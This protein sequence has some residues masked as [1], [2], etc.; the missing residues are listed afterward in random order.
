MI[1][2]VDRLGRDEHARHSSRPL[3]PDK[4]GDQVGFNGQKA[5]KHEYAHRALAKS[6]LDA[7]QTATTCRKNLKRCVT[8]MYERRCTSD[9]RAKKQCVQTSCARR[10]HMRR[11]MMDIL[12][13]PMDKS[14]PLEL[15]EASSGKDGDVIEGA[16]FCPKCS[17]FYPIIDEIPIM[18]PDE[19]RDKGQEIEFL[20]RCRERLPEKITGAA[21]PWHI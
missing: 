9:R 1:A 13:C 18:L 3:I 7:L 2:H 21:N 6:C 12:A 16:L 14:F 5:F 19:L 17:R 4:K 15:F 11:K 20:E 8:N 10:D